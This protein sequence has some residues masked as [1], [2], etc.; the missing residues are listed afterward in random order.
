MPQI[1]CLRDARHKHLQHPTMKATR[2]LP[3]FLL[4]AT[5]LTGCGDDQPVATA[6]PQ[7]AAPSTRPVP[8]PAAKPVVLLEKFDV[9]DSVYVRSLAIE[10]E[11]GTLWVGT[12]AGVHE[13]DLATQTL[14]NT[15]TRDDG[16][17]NEY[18]FSI[19]IDHQGYKWFGTNAGGV[20]RY[21][22]GD[23][24]T[25]FP[26]HGLAD[27]W[28]YSFGSQRDGSLWIGTWA[29]VNRVDPDSGEFTT[30]VEE[31]VN[32][33]VYSI[34]VDSRDRVWF[35]TEGGVSMFDGT[36]WREW[37]HADGIS[38][39]NTSNLQV[40]PNTGLGTRRRHDLGILSGGLPSYNP[41]YVFAMHIDADDTVWIGTWGGGVGRY[42]GENWTTLTSRDGLAGD[43][44]Y[45][46]ARTPDGAYW[47]GTNRGLSRFDGTNW[48]TFTRR[49]GLPQNDV[50]S[51]AVDPDGSIWAGTRGGVAHFGPAR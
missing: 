17:A 3:P 2:L 27:Y 39:A 18:V 41:D 30:Y 32:E 37:T 7:P 50:Y 29:G 20:S 51:L 46:I 47:F 35:G 34:G 24:K 22:D 6:Q 9:G 10:A 11:R 8:A 49:D 1:D 21:R 43:I 19:G 31:L 14:R 26:M 45:S 44:V 5:L 23:W 36:T 13:V 16:L 15:F 48:Q 4:A 12:S 40:S 33:W 42:D 25:F 28:V 38:A